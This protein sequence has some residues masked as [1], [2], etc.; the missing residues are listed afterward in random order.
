MT[1]KNET[2]NHCKGE[3]AIF[4]DLPVKHWDYASYGNFVQC[5]SCEGTGVFLPHERELKENYLLSVV[6]F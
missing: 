2:C 5:D 6:E 4:L 3:G 1:E